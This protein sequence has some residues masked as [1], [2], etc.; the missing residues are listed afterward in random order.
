MLSFKKNYT[1]EFAEQ[2]SHTHAGDYSQ[3]S[4]SV[5]L[6]LCDSIILNDWPHVVYSK[7][8]HDDRTNTLKQVRIS[9]PSVTK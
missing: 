6:S 9:F 8:F 3:G 4:H 2:I 7:G 1:E 5:L